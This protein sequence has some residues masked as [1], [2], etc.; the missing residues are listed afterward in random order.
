MG[1][2]GMLGTESAF[3]QCFARY[4]LR[5]CLGKRASQSEQ[6]WTRGEQNG[7]CSQAHD[8]ATGVDD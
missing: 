4:I 3:D 8:I 1:I 6:H 7:C 2:V 5:P